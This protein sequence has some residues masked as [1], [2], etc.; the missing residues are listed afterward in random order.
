MALGLGIV[1]FVLAAV[2]IVAVSRSS[3]TSTPVLIGA[4]VLAA[5]LMSVYA[6]ANFVDPSQVPTRASNC[7]RNRFPT[8]DW[9]SA[10]RERDEQRLHDLARQVERCRLGRGQTGAYVR[11]LLGPPDRKAGASSERLWTYVVATERELRIQ[12]RGGYAVSVVTA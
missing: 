3:I 7:D 1:L 2:L 9:L 4:V 12:F 8:S 10:R 5:A 6:V 11:A